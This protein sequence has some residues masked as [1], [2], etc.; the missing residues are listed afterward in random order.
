MRWTGVRGGGWA[1]T[2]SWDSGLLKKK[3]P[4][5]NQPKRRDSVASPKASVSSTSTDEAHVSPAWAEVLN[6]PLMDT[7]VSFLSG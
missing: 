6:F 5:P 3:N 7:D 1:Y 4:L 2:T